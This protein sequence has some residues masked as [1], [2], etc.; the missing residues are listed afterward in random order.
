MVAQKRTLTRAVDVS[1]FP[2]H[3]PCRPHRKL[4]AVVGIL[5][6]EEHDLTAQTLARKAV[7]KPSGAIAKRALALGAFDLN[8]IIH[9]DMVPSRKCSDCIPALLRKTK[10]ATASRLMTWFA[11]TNPRR[12][13]GMFIPRA[14]SPI[15]SSA[16]FL[17]P[18]SF[19]L[20]AVSI[21]NNY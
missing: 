15:L 2:P 7:L 14:A 10:K 17:P 21:R 12:T 11:P 13:D 20:N 3:P 18:L 4:D 1:Q 9:A 8:G 16:P 19:P 6:E 5:L